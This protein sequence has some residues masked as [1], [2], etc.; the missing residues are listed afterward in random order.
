MRRIRFRKRSAFALLVAVAAG[1][2]AMPAAAEPRAAT[3]GI[4]QVDYFPQ[5]GFRDGA[6]VGVA[7]DLFDA[8]AAASGYRLTFRPVPVRRL[9]QALVA[10]DIDAKYPDSP[11]WDA[12]TKSQAEQQG[13]ILR[14]SGPV[15]RF[16]NG[17][18]VPP[19]LAGVRTDEIASLVTILGFT[20]F[21]WQD[22]ID[23]GKVKLGTAPGAEATLRNAI[24]G[25]SDAAYLSVAVA[26]FHMARTIGQPDALRFDPALPHSADAYRLSSVA[27]PDLIAAFDAWLAENAGLAADIK[28]RYLAEDGID[29]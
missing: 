4:E 12:E 14:Y 1:L 18:L 13:R 23:A 25:R 27:R 6:F 26:R 20:P 15:V 19:S 9:V 8:F 17:T 22:R 3:I 10:G 29:P 5:Y 24:A 21:A 16:V 28:A 2:F 7:R 11:N